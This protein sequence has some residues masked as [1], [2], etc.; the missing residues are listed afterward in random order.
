MVV[1]VNEEEVVVVHQVHH[2]YYHVLPDV[3]HYEKT[4]QFEFYYILYQ[5]R[6]QKSIFDRI[7]LSYI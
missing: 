2:H 7:D 5:Y 3:D 6:D 1:V 4:V